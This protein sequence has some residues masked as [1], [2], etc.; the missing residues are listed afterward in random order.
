MANY[1]CR[2]TGSK[3]SV[4]AL[5]ALFNDT[6]CYIEMGNQETT[7]FLYAS[8]INMISDISSAYDFAQEVVIRINSIAKLCV[9]EFDPVKFNGIAF[10]AE[11]GTYSGIGK[12]TLPNLSFLAKNEPNPDLA[13]K[14][15]ELSQSN[16]RVAEVFHYFNY[17]ELN[18]FDLYR[19]YEVICTDIGQNDKVRGEYRL[20]KELS[21]IDKSELISFQNTTNRQRHRYK[22]VDEKE[23]SNPMFVKDAEIFI[24]NLVYKWLHD[25]LE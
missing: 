24:V 22:T 21:W 8:E 9:G 2:L 19:I 4:S 25:K 6:D 5:C 1:R 16:S 14:Y 20:K 13:K 18:W 23:I 3:E 11:D 10:P 17:Q 12:L 7:C 15:L